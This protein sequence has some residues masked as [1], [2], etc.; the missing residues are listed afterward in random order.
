M[1]PLAVAHNTDHDGQLSLEVAMPVGTVVFKHAMFTDTRATSSTSKYVPVCPLFFEHAGAYP[2]CIH[3]ATSTVRR[4]ACSTGCQTAIAR[5][6]PSSGAFGGRG[7]QP[8]SII[9][10]A[11]PACFSS[12]FPAMGGMRTEARSGRFYDC[13]VGVS[14]RAET[15][16]HGP[17]AGL[18]YDARHGGR[19]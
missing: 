10:A 16:A 14:S 8:S 18:S 11:L 4:S 2:F 3:T 17:Q 19:T 12:S 9:G 5:V 6:S 7:L 13:C 1:A 15:S